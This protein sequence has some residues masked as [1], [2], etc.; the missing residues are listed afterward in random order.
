M[1]TLSPPKLRSPLDAQLSAI[2]L[3]DH[4]GLTSKPK[5]ILSQ[6]TLNFNL[7]AAK[8]KRYQNKQ[9]LV[10]KEKKFSKKQLNQTVK[11]TEQDSPKQ[12]GHSHNQCLAEEFGDEDV[13]D[14]YDGSLKKSVW[15]PQFINNEQLVPQSKSGTASPDSRELERSKLGVM[16]ASSRFKKKQEINTELADSHNET[17]GTKPRPKI[18]KIKRNELSKLLTKVK[19]NQTLKNVASVY[20][21]QQPSTSILDKTTQSSRARTN[22]IKKQYCSQVQLQDILEK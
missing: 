7:L 20:N 19:S 15:S 11:S 1:A 6:S 8:M 2:T 12:S 3:A 18:D 13:D 16:K 14:D 22:G 21:V 4:F 9:L 17:Q 10:D 5:P